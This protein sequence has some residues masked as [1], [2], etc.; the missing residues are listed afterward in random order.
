[1]NA[2]APVERAQP[3]SLAPRSDSSAAS[4]QQIVDEQDH[5]N[6]DE[7][8]DQTTTEMEYKSEQPYHEQD[9]NYCPQNTGHVSSFPGRIIGARACLVGNLDTQAAV[10]INGR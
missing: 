2:P 3:L 5:C 7:D 6:D 9:D 10:L 8:V 4:R 1:M